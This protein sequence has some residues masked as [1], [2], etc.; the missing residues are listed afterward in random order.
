MF[1]IG[2]AC[3]IIAI[4]TLS[5]AGALVLALAILAYASSIASAALGASLTDATLAHDLERLH[6][7]FGPPRP[8]DAA[9]KAFHAALR[10][11][12]HPA[13]PCGIDDDDNNTWCRRIAR[14][15]GGDRLRAGVRLVD[16]RLQTPGFTSSIIGAL[17]FPS[18]FS[19]CER[20]VVHA[21]AAALGAHQAEDGRGRRAATATTTRVLEVGSGAGHCTLAMASLL[22]P[23]AEYEF[24]GI[25]IAPQRV[26]LARERARAFPNV[27]FHVADAAYPASYRMPAA[28][29]EG[30]AAGA[31]RCPPPPPVVFDV[32]LAV[33]SAQ[34]LDTHHAM[35]AF[36][37]Q[38]ANHLGDA[39]PAGRVIIVDLFRSEHFDQ[40]PP[41]QQR[42]ARFAERALRVARLRPMSEWV[43]AAHAAGL[44][45]VHMEDLTPQ[46]MPTLTLAWRC[47]HA[48]LRHAPAWAVRRI[49]AAIGEGAV[50]PPFLFAAAAPHALRD[51]A[52]AMYGAI[53]FAKGRATE[54]DAR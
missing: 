45:L 14:A 15:L 24:H 5:P 39:A 12:E 54:D 2:T 25:D 19:S 33:E 38:A 41:D 47:A 22:L 23:A 42:A 53:V 9:P 1:G 29:E 6:A 16:P 11:N 7:V 18:A 35:R 51:R 13:P 46:A 17:L 26:E 34:H 40:S 36:L 52:S 32:I 49:R 3:A 4:S 27:R 43:E 31:P 44:R 30:S 21:V 48:V 37:T 50:D 28:S 20:H 10:H 8:A